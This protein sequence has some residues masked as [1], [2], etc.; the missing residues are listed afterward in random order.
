MNDNG[1]VTAVTKHL[2]LAVK[3][4]RVMYGEDLLEWIEAERAAGKDLRSIAAG[5]RW[6]TD[7]AIDV[8]AQTVLNWSNVARQD[9]A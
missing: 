3:L 1:G 2:R 4:W 8:T 9:A 7:G 6:A 5:L